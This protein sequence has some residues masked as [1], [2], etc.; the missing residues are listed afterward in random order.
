MTDSQASC[1]LCQSQFNRKLD[2]IESFGF[3]VQYYLCSSCG[4]VF[5]DSAASQAANPA[6]YAETY[7]KLY[8]QSEDPT[9][10]DLRQQKLR[11][12]HLLN[13]LRANRADHPQRVLDIGASSGM[14][15]QTLK[16]ETGAEVMGVEPGNAYRKLAQSHGIKV[17]PS[18]ENLI[19]GGEEPFSLVTLMHVL[20]HF[21]N[22]LETLTTIREKLLHPQGWLV[23]EVPNFYGHGSMELAHLSCFTPHSLAEMLK[24]SGY[25]LV[26]LKEHGWP[27]S[28]ILPLYLTALA[29]PLPSNESSAVVP[30]K[31][32]ALK[33]KIAML[34]R[35][36]LQRTQPAKAWLPLED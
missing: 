23:V 14:L 19:T 35:Y 13:F 2:Q 5:Q 4:F 6:F 18:L 30:E 28:E 7:R 26:T 16:Q 31:N 36:W 27:R 29:K 11:A 20:E 17:Y 12:D 21:P 8:Q 1:P 32:V 25:R 24:Q 15:L 3:P 22:P 34:K 9:P 33:R 10:K